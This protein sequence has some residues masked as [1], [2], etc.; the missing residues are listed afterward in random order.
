MKYHKGIKVVKE[1]STP[2]VNK[3]KIKRRKNQ[4]VNF[5]SKIST[6]LQKTL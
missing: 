6:P 1:A 2:K 4:S 3:K 5:I